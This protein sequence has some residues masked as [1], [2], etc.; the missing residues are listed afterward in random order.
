MT[1]TDA[2]VKIIFNLLRTISIHERFLMREQSKTRLLGRLQDAMAL[3]D[4]VQDWR[5]QRVA[6]TERNEVQPRVLFPVGKA[7]T[8]SESHFPE[9]RLL[10]AEGSCLP[11]A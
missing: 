2:T 7:A 5:R 1:C 11:G 4:L 3:E 6:K 8:I 10:R 9:A